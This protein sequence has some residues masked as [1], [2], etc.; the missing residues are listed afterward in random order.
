MRKTGSG[1]QDLA[2]L[3]LQQA[4]KNQAACDES[5][6]ARAALPQNCLTTEDES[7]VVLAFR[8]HHFGNILWQTP[9]LP[10]AGASCPQHRAYPAVKQPFTQSPQLKRR[11]DI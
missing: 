3:I 7:R 11:K 10:W 8:P 6:D 4:Y 1:L 9:R 5:Q 2:G